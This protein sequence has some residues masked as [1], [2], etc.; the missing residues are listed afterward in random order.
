RGRPIDRRYIERFLHDHA[1]DIRGHVLEVGDAAYTR[2]FG[3]ENVTRSD[4][5]HVSESAP[6][7]TIIADLSNGDDLPSEAFD[8]IILTQTLHLLYD[9]RKAVHTFHRML[10]PAGV[11]LLT[12][13][14]VSAIDHGEWGPSWHW[15]FTGTSLGKLLRDQ[16]GAD[17]VQVSQFGNVL[18]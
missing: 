6:E 15:S 17:A 2:A 3:G 4:V 11:L 13:P 8:C 1:A 16:F 7:A 18:A 14:G 9:L 12:V 5:L 10:K